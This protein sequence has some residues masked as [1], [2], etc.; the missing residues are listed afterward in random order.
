MNTFLKSVQSFFKEQEVDFIELDETS[1][2]TVLS[3]SDGERYDVVL[4]YFEEDDSCIFSL[5][6]YIDLNVIDK[7]KLLEVINYLNVKNSVLGLT[8]YLLDADE[9]NKAILKTS[10]MNRFLN[11]ECNR[12]AESFYDLLTVMENLDKIR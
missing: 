12:I 3:G 7:Q 8:M 4:M 10:S 1:I 11:G 9:N 2:G 6:K 5:D